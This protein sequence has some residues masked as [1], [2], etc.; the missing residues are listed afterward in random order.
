MKETI[1]RI[2]KKYVI[3]SDNLDRISI[4]IET[5]LKKQQIQ[6]LN[7]FIDAAI[8]LQDEIGWHNMQTL[9]SGKQRRYFKD[10]IHILKHRFFKS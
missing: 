4:E 8:E 7:Y 6:S 2:L 3:D 5:K 1:L 10:E 9:H